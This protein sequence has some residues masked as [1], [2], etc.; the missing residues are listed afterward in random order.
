MDR[1]FLAAA[2]TGAALI[3]APGAQAQQPAARPAAGPPPPYGMPI[4]LEAAKKVAAAA[5]EKTHQTHFPS[6]IAIVGPAGDLI[7]LEKMD[8]TNNA[9]VLLAQKKAE[10][11][12]GFRRPTEFFEDRVNKGGTFLLGLTGASV[13]GGGVPLVERGH[14]VGAIGVSGAPSSAGDVEAADAGAAALK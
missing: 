11:A 2:L 13:V 4:S 8:G 7:Y 6:T 3:L 14:V 12:A 1:A 5:V 9:T 10:G